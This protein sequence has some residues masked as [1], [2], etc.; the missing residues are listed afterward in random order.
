MT[1]RAR[2]VARRRG[3]AGWDSGD[4]RNSLINAGFFLAIGVAILLLAGYTI[5]SWYDSH[6]GAAAV[7][8]GTVIT[9]DEF[10]TRLKIETFRIDYQGQRIQTEQARGHLTAEEADQRRQF[11]NQA[12]SQ[13]AGIAL[14][15]LVDNTLQ[16]SLATE[17]GVTVSEADVD[18]AVTDEATQAEQRHV[19]MIEV[20]PVPNPDTGEVGDE[21]KR[22]AL[23]EAQRALAR[24][25]G[26]ESWDDVARTVSDAA[27]APQAGDVGWIIKDS[28]YDKKLMDAIFAAPLN[29]TTDVV[30][31]DDGVYRIG[32]A[33]ET[34]A[35]EVDGD[36]DSKL[37]DAQIQ[38]AD[39]RKAIRGDVVRTKLSDKVVADMSQPG[40]QRHVL[41]IYLPEPNQSSAGEE[42]GVKV[43]WIVF[44]P[45]DTTAGA[46]KLPA[47]DPAWAKAKADADAAYA[48]LKA[49]PERFDELARAQS[50]E[51]VG[52]SNG[53]KQRWIYGSTPI[54]TK[55]K[56][57]VL[58][59]GLQPGQLLE[60]VRGELGYY[61]IQFMRPLGDGDEAW[62]E[63]VKAKI[64]DDASF[65][66][67]ARDNSE[68]E[69]VAEGGD[70]GWI[71]KGQLADELDKA[72][73]A[74]AVG[75]NSDVIPIQG[76]GVYLIRVLA[77]ETRTP[78]DEQK[79]IF[80]SG[81]FQYWYTQKKGAAKIDYK[82]GSTSTT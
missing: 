51:S 24:L 72:V 33:T 5:W 32:R 28:G 29:Q 74:T 34:A 31:G 30:E 17:N 62:L 9:K 1:L 61:L 26:G 43:R 14:E 82:I 39:F 23:G 38:L 41:E 49:H 15:R 53:G 63:S 46:D 45:K 55:V 76:D 77:E 37:E 11:L 4:R 66:Q 70:L 56:E 19:W 65:R 81:G 20:E 69:K 47:D 35:A 2:P 27:N 78:T 80:E 59:A 71:A 52:K 44:A 60:P 42:D 75:S 3:R 8:N 79:K 36:F 48:E 50:D 6:F 21:E 16:G 7:V 67:A 54:D 40:P 73:F 12:R 58:A 13:L 18:K 10:L 57:P 22:T 68:G 64:T 25:K